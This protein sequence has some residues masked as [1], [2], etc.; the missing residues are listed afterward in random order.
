MTVFITKTWGFGYP[1]GPLQFGAQGD[2]DRARNERLSEGDFVVYVG[3][4]NEPTPEEERGRL[5][6]LVEPTKLPVRSLDYPVDQNPWDFNDDGSYKWPYG[7]Q[8]KKA[9]ILEDRPL[10]KSISD[11]KFGRDSARTIVP[12]TEEESIQVLG[13]RRKAVPLSRPLSVANLAELKGEATAMKQTAPPPTTQRAGCMHMRRHAA[14]TYAMS[15]E[16]ASI[17]AF[18]VGWSFSFRKRQKQFNQAS[19]PMLGGLKYQTKLHKLWDTARQ[20]FAMEQQVLYQLREMRHRQNSEVVVGLTEAEL[21]QVW[22]TCV[23]IVMIR[24]QRHIN[25]LELK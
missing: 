22:N 12:L 3:T 9:W 4:L 20:A 25:G 21:L 5:L 11:R 24:T 2:R 10:L 14:F 16:G 18:K 23:E 17:S 7:L 13:L 19:M 6:A 1:A 8:L 15:I